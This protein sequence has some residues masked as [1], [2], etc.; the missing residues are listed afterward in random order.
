MKIRTWFKLGAVLLFCAAAAFLLLRFNP[1]AWEL[2]GL[3]LFSTEKISA[4]DM[5]LQETRAVYRLNTVELVHKSVF[6]L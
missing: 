2:P 3:S 6:S 5:L 1:F 4:R